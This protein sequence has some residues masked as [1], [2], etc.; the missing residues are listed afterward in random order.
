MR[1]VRC[2]I[3]FVSLACL[4][5]CI[6]R[7]EVVAILPDGSAYLLT[8]I[9]GAPQDVAEGDA[10][11]DEKSG[12]KTRE[13]V[14]TDDKGK[15]TLHR[16]AER[17]ADR[18]AAIPGDYAGSD[19]AAR[20]V[21]LRFPTSIKIERRPD[22][23]YYHF[24]RTYMGRQYARIAYWQQVYLEND[25]IKAISKKAPEDLTD[26]DRIKLAEALIAADAH[27]T[28]AFVEWAVEEMANPIPQDA[29]LAARSAAIK[30][31][32]DELTP[33]ALA[34]IIKQEGG[35]EQAVE[36]AQDV[37]ERAVEQMRS[38]LTAHQ[39]G[40]A[41]RDEFI[42]AYYTVRDRFEITED[43]ADENWQVTV[44]LPGTIIAHNSRSE[45]SVLDIDTLRGDDDFGELARVLADTR[46]RPGYSL[47]EW[48]FDAKPLLSDRDVVLAATS[49][50][51]R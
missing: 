17:R 37:H 30:T 19:A 29:W 34:E 50:V 4:C 39:V 46:F 12:W 24:R 49:F 10:L 40:P 26:E 6:K 11:P 1:F 41:L 42:D 3:W 27:K 2:G 45:P 8:R 22:G 16:T 43:I 28:G 7:Q 25:D 21:C 9:E 51:P 23:T 32:A 5:G 20:E 38:V 44:A 14:V 36:L 33:E 48:K 18:G 35:A 15:K 13:N 31:Y 47:V